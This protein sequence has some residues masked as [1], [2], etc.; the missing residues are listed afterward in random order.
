MSSDEWLE[1]YNKVKEKVEELNSICRRDNNNC[2]Y[3]NDDSV[4][5]DNCKN[6]NKCKFV[7]RTCDAQPK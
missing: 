1:E 5:C 7:I 3:I 4:S 2:P 6:L